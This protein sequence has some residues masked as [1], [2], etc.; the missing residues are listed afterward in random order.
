MPSLQV[1]EQSFNFAKDMAS[2]QLQAILIRAM[3]MMTE[4]LFK[5]TIAYRCA[6]DVTLPGFI[7][8]RY[9]R[10]E[11]S[12]KEEF[13]MPRVEMTIGYKFLTTPEYN[14]VEATG[15]SG[16]KA[17]A[18]EASRMSY[19]EARKVRWD[20]ASRFG[21]NSAYVGPQYDRHG[22]RVAAT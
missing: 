16:W 8:W 12:R 19:E 21:E 1:Q 17:E 7:S 11:C 3:P 5:K 15:D 18:Q 6:K 2:L 10:F 22:T 9:S 4:E 13:G 20:V 14:V